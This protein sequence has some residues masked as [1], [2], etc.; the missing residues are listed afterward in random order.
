MS[1]LNCQWCWKMVDETMKYSIKEEHGQERLE[2]SL[3]SELVDWWTESTT[4]LNFWGD[5]VSNR[6]LSDICGN[7]SMTF[8]RKKTNVHGFCTVT[9]VLAEITGASFKHDA[10]DTG[11]FSDNTETQTTTLTFSMEFLKVSN[12]RQINELKLCHCDIWSRLWK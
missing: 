8:T 4:K 11:P 3:C 7:T 9:V 1:I 6:E 10:G 2:T 5:E 12:S